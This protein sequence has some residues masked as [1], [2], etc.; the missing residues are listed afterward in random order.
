M[1]KEN[2]KLSGAEKAAILL[3][4][5]GEDLASEV[6]RFMTTEEMHKVGGTIIKKESVPLHVGRQV[7]GE[8]IDTVNSGDMAVEGLEFAKNLITKALGPE[9]AKAVVD[10]LTRDTRKGGIESLKWM[11]PDLVANLIK[12]EHPQIIALI[13]THF[14]PE[15]AAQV[16]LNIADERVRGEVMLRIATLKTIPISAVKDLE[17]MLNEHMLNADSSQGNNVEGVKVA[18]EIMNHIEF[19]VGSKSDNSIMDIIEKISPDIAIKI[20]EKM[21]V[22]ADIIEIDDRGVQQI[23]K[24]VSSEILT[25][26]LKGADDALKDKFLKNMSERAA[27]LLKE[28][29]EAK[30]PVKLS[31]VEKAQQEVIKVVRGLEQEGKIVRRGGDVV[32]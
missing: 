6:F 32:F 17:L 22:F 3:M 7:V 30:G 16:L 24:E 5:L 13:L 8:F 29:M 11:D 28:D 14:D 9:K 18:A 26:A 21:F 23:I 12:S 25:I 1:S 20:Q 15:R 27:E 4:N 10:Q 19:F 2:T 31:D